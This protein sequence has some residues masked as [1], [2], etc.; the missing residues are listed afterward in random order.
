VEVGP[1]CGRTA[2]SN[3]L[4]EA[5]AKAEREDPEVAAAAASYDRMVDRVI[6][7]GPALSFEEIR[8]IYDTPP[9]SD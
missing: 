5:V 2:V 6:G 3:S 9:A 7:R 4:S 8:R 1:C